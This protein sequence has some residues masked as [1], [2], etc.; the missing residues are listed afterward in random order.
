LRIGQNGRIFLNPTNKK[1][2]ELKNISRIS[3]NFE[4]A[5]HSRNFEK[6]ST[7]LGGMQRI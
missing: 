5:K 7:N 1:K 6:I 4:E 2:D 3:K